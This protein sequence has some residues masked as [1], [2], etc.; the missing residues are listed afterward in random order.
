MRISAGRYT[1]AKTKHRQTKQNQI[2]KNISNYVVGFFFKSMQ[3][4]C[5]ENIII[6]ILP[7]Y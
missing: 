4:V 6:I 2:Q 1:T 7:L 3:K 5:K